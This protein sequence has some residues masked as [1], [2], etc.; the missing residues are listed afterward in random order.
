MAIR[1][2]I[3]YTGNLV[4]AKNSLTMLAIGKIL[5]QQVNHS[6]YLDQVNK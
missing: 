2:A 4:A 3:Y 6:E 5:Y 1:Y